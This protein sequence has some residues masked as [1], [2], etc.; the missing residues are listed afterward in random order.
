M[1]GRTNLQEIKNACI[2]LN[3][4]EYCQTTSL[5]LEERVKGKIAPELRD[6][7]SFQPERD[8]FTRYADVMWSHVPR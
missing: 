7:L 6:D 3:T 8:H 1:E 5:Q 2:I 4:A